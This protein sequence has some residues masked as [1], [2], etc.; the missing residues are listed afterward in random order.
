M[1]TTEEAN[2]RSGPDTTYERLGKTEAGKT[3]MVT[4]QSEDGKWYRIL[5]DG[6]EAYIAAE[7]LTEVAE[8][9]ALEEELAQKSQKAE[10]DVET[11][12]KEETAAQGQI[13][14]SQ[15]A[16]EAVTGTDTSAGAQKVKG[17][18]TPNYGL[19]IVAVFVL[20]E[21]I[22]LY[23]I[24]KIQKQNIIETIRQDNI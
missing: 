14:G 11:A 3:C 9:A 12:I 5:Y 18:N 8:D 16:T 19:I 24:H 10:A 2:L 20:L 1:Q 22:M 23:S 21:A 17:Q 13:A 4:G 6:Q 7:Y 15:N